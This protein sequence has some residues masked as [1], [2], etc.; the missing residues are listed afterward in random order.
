MI[1]WCTYCSAEKRRDPAPLPAIERYLDRRIRRVAEGAGRAG[2][3]F[4]ILSGAYGLLEPQAPIP[5]YDHLLLDEEVE[6][7]AERVA[8]QLAA[9]GVEELVFHTV[10]EDADP[11]TLPY[12]QVVERACAAADVACSVVVIPA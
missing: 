3:A 7:M 9:A 1:A 10:G 5:W 4:F 2:A 12:R 6:A 8:G 11:H